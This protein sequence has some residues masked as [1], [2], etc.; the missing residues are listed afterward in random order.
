[1][2]GNILYFTDNCGEIVF[3]KLVCQ[4]LTTYDVSLTLVVK[5]VPI[6]TDATIEDALS[7]QLDE[8]VNNILTTEVFAVGIDF[9]KISDRLRNRLQKA[10]LIICKGMANYEAFSEKSYKPIAYFLKAKC[11]SIAED[12][13]APLGA[14]VIKV[15]P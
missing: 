6:L 2:K 9:E 12:I 3:D 11:K 15:Y 1:L 5:G 14:N 13:H 8:V 7:L 10:N 4:E